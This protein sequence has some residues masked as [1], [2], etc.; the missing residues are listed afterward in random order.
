MTVKRCEMTWAALDRIE[1]PAERRELVAVGG[2]SAAVAP[3]S[4]TIA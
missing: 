2:Y 1:S 4:T 3:A